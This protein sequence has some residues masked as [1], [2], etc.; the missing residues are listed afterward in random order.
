MPQVGAGAR[1][2]MWAVQDG[3]VVLAEG[4]RRLPGGGGTESA[5]E[6][7]ALGGRGAQ[8]SLDPRDTARDKPLV[9]V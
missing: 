2:S 3:L 7:P 4:G 9:R 1:M 8:L 5:R 6:P